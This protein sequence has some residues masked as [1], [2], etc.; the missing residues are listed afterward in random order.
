MRETLKLIRETGARVYVF[1]PS[2]NFPA[3][4]P[5]IAYRQYLFGS[6]VE[7]M[8]ANTYT[9]LRN[10]MMT[11]DGVTLID[12]VP[13]FCGGEECRFREG[14]DLYFFDEGHMTQLGVERVA[15]LPTFQGL[16]HGERQPES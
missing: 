1:G 4:V 14:R 15:S 8:K 10:E 16:L 2:P 7:S 3:A 12:P 9:V 5:S 11:L 6:S 13:L